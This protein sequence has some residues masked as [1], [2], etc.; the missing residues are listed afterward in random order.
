MTGISGLG[1]DLV[2][3]RRFRRFVL[4]G[5]VA[6]LE[7]L[8]DDAEREYCLSKKD[9][10][11]HLAVR[12]AAKEA[13]LKALGTGLRQ[14]IRW[15]DIIVV[16]DAAGKPALALQGQAARLFEENGHKRHLL[17]CTH[18]GDYAFA[19][20]VFESAQVC[21]SNR[22]E[23]DTSMLKARDIMTVDVHT[24]SMETSVEELARLFVKTKVSAMPVVDDE[25][26]L[27]GIV[28]ETDLVSQDQALHIPTVV[29]LFDWVVY[30]ES[31][32]RFAEQVRKM[33]ARLVQE[34]CTRDVATCTPDAP[35][36]EIVSLMLDKGIH[37]VPVVDKGKL[38][39]VVARLDIIRSMEL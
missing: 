23:R 20:V 2:A 7:R 29:S 13:F 15:R 19:T 10:A 37:M 27:Q 5:K 3:V 22:F 1:N 6:L 21:F 25:G 24:V 26:M 28:T 9:P 17:S 33:T 11:P 4:E 8:F 35:V 38:L 39:G 31:E 30:L 14:G 16:R 12:Y 18:D 36:S 32:D 34:I